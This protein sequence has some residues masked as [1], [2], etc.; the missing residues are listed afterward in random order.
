[1]VGRPG[2]PLALRTCSLHSLCE[3]IW[4]TEEDVYNCAMLSLAPR[5]HNVGKAG[6]DQI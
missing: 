2:A 5:I 4:Q 1:M 3:G 6:P